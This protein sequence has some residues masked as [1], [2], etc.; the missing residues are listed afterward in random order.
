MIALTLPTRKGWSGALERLGVGFE[1]G[2]FVF[3]LEADDGTPVG[4]VRYADDGR[5]PKMLADKGTTRELWPRPEVVPGRTIFEV[6]GEPDA[7]TM[8]E[9]D[10]PASGYPGTGKTD[11]EWPRRLIFGP[12][13]RRE[14]VVF[15]PDCDTG[16]RA[17]ARAFASDVAALGVPAFVAD[18]APERHDG[19]DVGDLLTEALAFDPEHGRETARRWIEACVEA[20][21]PVPPA[22][23]DAAEPAPRTRRT[24]T[25]TPA[26]AIR[27]ERGRWLWR[28]RFPLRGLTVVAG[29]KG[30]GKSILTNAHIVAAITRGT[31]E[32]ELSGTPA[33]V[34]IVTAE[35]DWR[36]V[37]KPRLMAANAD[38]DRVHR[39]EVHDADGASILTLPDDVAALEAE[40]AH[41]RDAGRIVAM[42]VVDPIG[43]FVPETANTH[44]DAPVRRILAPLAALA[45]RQDL[46]VIAVMHLTK[47]EAKRLIQRVSG[48]GAFVNAARSYLA[49]V[50]DPD[51]ADGEQGTRRLIVHVATN[52]G[53]Y[54][55]TLL[56]HVEAR[57]VDTDDGER[58]E[59]GYLIVDGESTA[60]VD[61][62][63]RGRDD[64]DD[65]TDTE[66]AIGEALKAGERRS[67]DVK[68]EVAERLGCSRKTVQRA[69]MR[70]RDRGE[71]TVEKSGFPPTSTW[72]LVRAHEGGSRVPNDENDAVEP[73]PRVPNG[74][75]SNGACPQRE[76]G[77]VEPNPTTSSAIGDTHAAV[78]RA[79]VRGADAH[80]TTPDLRAELA[81]RAGGHTFDAPVDPPE[82]D[83]DR[84]DWRQR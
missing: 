59:V 79:H 56:V 55:P 45:D 43:A 58:A 60:T 72:T 29:E 39:V 9:L 25:L 77:A 18:L 36:S 57:A 7:L 66:E 71:L 81:A 31:V 64:E 38:L 11:P 70:M 23:H 49:M 62:V 73:N 12:E 51:D 75:D 78:V 63:Q 67:L 47:D 8:A 4:A 3:R 20:A 33:D 69:A 34:L 6:E 35:D 17:K 10:L 14:R 82:R 80:G 26:S 50:K 61:D 30:L 44:A 32:G 19:F 54:A 83:D 46:A 42:V 28:D 27:S 1:A 48:A 16:G 84:E 40:I 5:E 68:A 37:V 15:I 65:P 22:L 41:L 74:N 76:N 24:V 21:E 2:R 13:G 52:W 53:T